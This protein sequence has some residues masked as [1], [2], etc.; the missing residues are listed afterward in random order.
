MVSREQPSSE[1]I[2]PTVLRHCRSLSVLAVR[3][4][5]EGCVNHVEKWITLLFLIEYQAAQI[6]ALLEYYSTLELHCKCERPLD[7]GTNAKID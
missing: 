1:L 2:I 6:E 5:I 4:G 7:F 3:Q